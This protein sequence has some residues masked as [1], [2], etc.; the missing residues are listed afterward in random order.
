MMKAATYSYAMKNAHP[1]IIEAAGF[2]TEKDN[3]EGGILD[4]IQA[5]CLTEDV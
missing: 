2:I 5:L 1:A 4:V 3:N